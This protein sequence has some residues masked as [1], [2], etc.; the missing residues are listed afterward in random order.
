MRGA[1]KIGTL[2][3]IEV[4]VHWS[5]GLLLLYVAFSAFKD[6]A[7]TAEIL[8]S[9]ALVLA[10]F[11]CV[12]LHELGHALAARRYGIKTRDIILLPIGGVARLE[13]MPVNPRQEIIVAV[14]GPLVNVVIA[15]A[16]QIV[17]VIATGK[18]LWQMAE[19]GDITLQT[20]LLSLAVSNLMLVAFNAIP[21]FPMDGGRV[22]R[23]TLSF[24]MPRPKATNIAAAI[25]RLFAMAFAL[26]G[27]Y[28]GHYW[29]L[30]TALFVYWAA[31]SEA[32]MVEQKARMD[33]LKVRNAM[34]N[35]FSPLFLGH[36]LQEAIDELLAGADTDFVVCNSQ[37]IAVGLLN[38]RDI[39]RAMSDG[40]DKNAPI[41]P[42]VRTNVPVLMP[43]HPLHDVYTMMQENGYNLLPVSEGGHLVGVIDLDNIAEFLLLREAAQ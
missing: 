12:T 2:A 4:F 21:A 14:A 30:L 33:G 6:G 36:S 43:E 11:G 18:L 41:E 8:F 40:Y 17:F 9:L 32:N 42:Y 20:F 16:I 27:I 26:F 19:I 28:I 38:R 37:L 34:R 15:L 39:I 10:I 31:S 1:F 25:G 13:S 7:A 24:F 3:G 35:K 23:A 29:L 22:L 5:F